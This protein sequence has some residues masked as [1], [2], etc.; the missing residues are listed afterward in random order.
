MNRLLT[1]MV[2][3]ALMIPALIGLRYMVSDIKD[4]W[5]EEAHE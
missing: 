3:L 4:I 2:Q 5:K 1:S